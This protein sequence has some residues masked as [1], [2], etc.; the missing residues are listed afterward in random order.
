MIFLLSYLLLLSP[1]PNPKL[2]NPPIDQ[3]AR[4]LH[5]SQQDRGEASPRL[6][7]GPGRERALRAE[8]MPWKK[9]G[10]AEKGAREGRG[11]GQEARLH[12]DRKRETPPEGSG[13]VPKY[14]DAKDRE[15]RLVRNGDK[16]EI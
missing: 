15:V 7:R 4:E 9:D 2:L 11:Q 14:K 6:S 8:L 12:P 5:P 16:I 13:R 10:A 1:S 3:A